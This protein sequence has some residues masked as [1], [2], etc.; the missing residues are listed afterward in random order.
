MML[1]GRK[2]KVL[3][4]RSLRLSRYKYAKAKMATLASFHDIL[5]N[6]SSICS[7]LE[8]Y[9]SWHDAAPL[10]SLYG[11]VVAVQPL[12]WDLMIMNLALRKVHAED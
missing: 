9:S 7:V 8:G 1:W 11:R 10:V 2:L 3:G 4:T 12:L 6:T 5:M